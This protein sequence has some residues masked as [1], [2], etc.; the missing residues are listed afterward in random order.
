MILQKVHKKEHTRTKHMNAH[1]QASNNIY[2]RYHSRKS[3]KISS[4]WPSPVNCSWHLEG[5]LNNWS[6]SADWSAVSHNTCALPMA[7]PISYVAT[8]DL[9]TWTGEDRLYSE[10]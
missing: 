10:S 6:E 7:W 9:E 1:V 3:H 2:T 5:P 4:Y 8:H